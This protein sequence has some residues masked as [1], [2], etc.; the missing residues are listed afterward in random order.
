[1]LLLVLILKYLGVNN[2]YARSSPPPPPTEAPPRR[3]G[4]ARRRTTPSPD[5]SP[6]SSSR[7]K[8]LIEMS[9]VHLRGVI[10][11]LKI[12][13]RERK[14]GDGGTAERCRHENGLRTLFYAY[15]SEII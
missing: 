3:R 15:G 10:V 2:E 12:G 14:D 4:T 7:K 9:R 13:D 5:G 11:E 1:M 6:S 8:I